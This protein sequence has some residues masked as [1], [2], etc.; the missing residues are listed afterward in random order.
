MR[1]SAQ[2]RIWLVGIV[3]LAIAGTGAL[4]QGTLSDPVVRNQRLEI[5]QARPA[6]DV[7]RLAA[8]RPPEP[9]TL[10]QAPEV[11]IEAIEL[12]KFEL[13]TGGTVTLLAVPELGEL[14]TIEVVQAGAEPVLSGEG[15][16][17]PL[18]VFLALAPLEMPIPQALIDMD[19]T[20]KAERLAAGRLRTDR[21]P[22][23][24]AVD[25]DDL[26]L[27]NQVGA[28]GS[29]GPGGS[30]HF[31]NNYCGCVLNHGGDLISFCD[32]GTW[33]SLIRSSH[34]GAWRAREASY[35]RTAACG[36]SVRIRQQWWVSGAW[37]TLSTQVMDSGEIYISSWHG[38]NAFRRIVR[39]R[40]AGGGYLR[41]YTNFHNDGFGTCP[42]IVAP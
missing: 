15:E 4:A 6:D 41:A 5:G 29:C 13:S 18:E 2:G 25:V 20:G 14:G 16:M 39:E 19:R 22:E 8:L 36:T 38:P 7:D 21:L 35:G 12:A 28:A 34:D 33:A 42:I 37:A 40:L 32:S 1:V 26:G 24:T 11:T 3:V 10:E 9:G 17:S 30:S 31:A 27:R 23:P